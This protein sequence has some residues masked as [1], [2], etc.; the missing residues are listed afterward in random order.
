ML[1]VIDAI[2]KLNDFSYFLMKFDLINDCSNLFCTQR[3]TRLLLRNYSKRVLASKLDFWMKLK[4]AA[5]F[6]KF[7]FLFFYSSSLLH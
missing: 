7:Y 4:I 2:V 5:Y 1:Q 3:G 6:S